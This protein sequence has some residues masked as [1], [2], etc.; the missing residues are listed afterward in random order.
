LILVMF[1][2]ML[3]APRQSRSQDATGTC[4][5]FVKKALND[6]G[7]N[8]SN[9][10]RNNACYGYNRLDATFSQQVT[11]N[12]FSKPTDRSEL[13]F[14]QS[15][16]TAALDVASNQWGVAVLS[17]QAN[18]PG[19]L[20]G[21]AVK[22]ILF[23][24]VKVENAVKP[25]EVLEGAAQPIK[26]RAVTRAN[27]RSG[28]SVN[29]NVVASVPAGAELEADALSADKRWL[30]V[31]YNQQTPGWISLDV[32]QADGDVNVL[33][34]ISRQARTPMQAFYFN[35]KVGDP[36]CNESPSLLVVQGPQK[37][38]VDITANGADI[39]L[40]STIVL[41]KSAND[42]MQIIVLDGGAKIGNLIIP[43]GFTVDIPLAPDGETPAGPLINLRPLTPE[44]L[45]QLQILEDLPLSL[46]NYKIEVPTED[47]IQQ[48][49][50][51]LAA[52]RT[53]GT[54]GAATG[55]NTGQV[56]CQPFKLTSPL[57]AWAY[58]VITFYWDAAPGAT[59]YRV[60]SNPGGTF[61]T[62]NTNVPIDLTGVDGDSLTWSVEALLNGQ[63]V[64]KAGPLS[65]VRD[66]GAGRPSPEP[67]KTPGP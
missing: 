6:F 23:G 2:F 9:L 41:K 35:T 64:C 34:I 55:G 44:E 7:N 38:A 12:F 46:L 53:G 54:G 51:R 67:L 26:A 39:R 24:D 32:A 42:K 20:P 14:L 65:L 61:E 8:C 29:T 31:A 48:I 37:V 18:L 58:R 21:Q 45:E 36:T 49:L 40:S 15:V 66:I 17:V 4:P 30:R 13:K 16:S 60:T 22:F 25:E 1:G 19:T 62:T 57:D 56:N 5:E 52:S 27:V 3:S 59:S 50:A 28:P 43:P 33:P 63:V 11:E 47:E 10:S